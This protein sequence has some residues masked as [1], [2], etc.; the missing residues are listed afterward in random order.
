MYQCFTNGNKKKQKI[1]Y[2]N[3]KI[4]L[5]IFKLIGRAE[6]ILAILYQN[7]HYRS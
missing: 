3:I 1:V 6:L 7:Y 5:Q 2:E 4:T